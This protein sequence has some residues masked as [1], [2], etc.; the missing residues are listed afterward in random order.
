MQ[1]LTAKNV[2]G[3][4]RRKVH[5]LL[6]ELQS[7][8]RRRARGHGPDAVGDFRARTKVVP[9]GQSGFPQDFPFTGEAGIL[10]APTRF[11]DDFTDAELARSYIVRPTD[12]DFGRHMNNV[13]YV[14]VLL[15]CFSAKQIASGTI[16]SIEGA[17]FRT[18]FGGRGTLGLSEAGRRY[19]PHR[20]QK[21]RWQARRPGC[22][23]LYRVSL[24]LYGMRLFLV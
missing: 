12:I 16:S 2:A 11:R 14:R 1:T 24:G 8:M 5:P 3:E 10:D 15:D 9:F 4:L 7:Q 20:H 23:P 6:P 13:A 19:R 17:L 21:A 18:V 22:R